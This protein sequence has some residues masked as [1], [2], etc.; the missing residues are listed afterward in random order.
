MV[1]KDPSLTQAGRCVAYR[2]G[3]SGWIITDP[4]Y[5]VK[6]RVL[7]SEIKTRTLGVCP[8]TPGKTMEHY[9]REEF[10]R[11]AVA[12][13]C[14]S[15]KELAREAQV[16]TVR[17]RVDDWETPHARRAANAGRLFQGHF[18]ATRLSKG[19]ELELEADLLTACQE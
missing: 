13:P 15:R 11:L 14:V 10:V 2:E 7:S 8:E 6:G 19:V 12:Q 4:V 16:G 3:G 1:F 18:L 17:F 9:S 5:Y